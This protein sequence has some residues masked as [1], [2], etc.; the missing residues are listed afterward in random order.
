MKLPCRLGGEYLEIS[1][2]E[3]EDEED[4]ELLESRR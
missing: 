1:W 3:D 4:S 2:Y